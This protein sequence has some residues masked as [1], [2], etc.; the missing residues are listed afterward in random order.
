MSCQTK[1]L[2]FFFSN[3][4]EYGNTRRSCDVPI[5][6]KPKNQNDFS[7][8][9]R[10]IY[11]KMAEFR[12]QDVKIFHLQPNYNFSEHLKSEI[13]KFHSEMCQT[14]PQSNSNKQ[15][16]QTTKSPRAKHKQKS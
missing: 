12:F 2:R 14:Q 1:S 10:F 5:G 6:K 11:I 13:F 3:S 4:F 15:S 16:P 8:K 7:N 9:F